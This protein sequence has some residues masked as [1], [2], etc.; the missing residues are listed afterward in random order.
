MAWIFDYI[1]YIRIYISSI[2]LSLSLALVYF[3][4]TLDDTQPKNGWE[5][6]ACAYVFDAALLDLLLFVV[7]VC[8]RARKTS[9]SPVHTQYIRLKNST[10]DKGNKS[11][12]MLYLLPHRIIWR[13]FF[14]LLLGS[15]LHSLPHIHSFASN[16]PLCRLSYPFFQWHCH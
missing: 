3:R 7:Y 4:V 11:S 9:F 16:H 10:S 14:L 8:A 15:S 2:S 13:V 6:L 12:L 1:L 5:C